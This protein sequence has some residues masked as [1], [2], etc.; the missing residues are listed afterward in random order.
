[1][2]RVDIYSASRSVANREPLLRR[3]ALDTMSVQWRRLAA[4][5][6]SQCSF[7]IGYFGKYARHRTNQ[8]SMSI[9]E[10]ERCAH[11]RPPDAV[12]GGQIHHSTSW[13]PV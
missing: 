10:P 9:K 4:G 6:A 5:L 1:M 11:Q 3:I 8:N 13:I 2:T 12:L 7:R